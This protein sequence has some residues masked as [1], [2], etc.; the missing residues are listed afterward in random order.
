MSVLTDFMGN[1]SM[2]GLLHI[3]KCKY[4]RLT[5]SIDDLDLYNFKKSNEQLLMKE[6][7]N[8]MRGILE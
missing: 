5:C 1:L 8:L 4:T 2:D 7:E 6:L 3:D